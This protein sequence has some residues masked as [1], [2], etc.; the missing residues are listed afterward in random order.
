[1]VVVF[2][3]F[4]RV[5]VGP[6]V[7]DWRAKACD[8]ADRPMEPKPTNN[9]KSVSCHVRYQRREGFSIRVND[10]QIAAAQVL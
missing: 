8:F 3:F 9:L 7:L 10:P 5:C 4:C 1:M 2:F 6:T